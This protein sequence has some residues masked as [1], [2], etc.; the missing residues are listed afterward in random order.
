MTATAPQ[1]SAQEPQAA[2]HIPSSTYR[3][4]LNRDFD[5]AAARKILPYLARLGVSDVYLS[6]IWASTPG[7]PHGYDVT[8]H[9]AVNPELGGMAGLRKFSA[10]ARELGLSVVVDFV[11]NHMGIQGGHNPYWEDVLMHGQ[12][13]RYAHFFDISWQ[14]LKRALEGKV[15]LP[16]LGE[17]YGRVL[18]NGELKLEQSEGRFFLRYW[19]RALP[20]S[21][22]S[23]ALV[24]EAAREHLPRARVSPVPDAVPHLQS[25]AVRAELSSL[26]RSV[27]NLPRS[28]SDA[29]TDEDR[30]D[31]AQE[32]DVMTR[33]LQAL[34]NTSAE[35]RG[36]LEAAL[37]A[38]NADTTRLDAIISEQ[39]YRLAFWKVA[40]EEINYRRFFDINDLAAL[41]M[42]DPRVFSW[43]HATLFELVR[44]GV[45]Q[46]VRL[47]HTDGLYDP[48]G[49]FRALQ[50]GAAEALGVDWNPE[51][52]G[53]LPLYVVAEKILE[54][55]EHLPNAWAVYGTTGYDFLAELN[56]VFVDATHE[57]EISAVYRRFTGDRLSYGEH[58]YRGKQLIQRVSLPGEVNV[59]TESLERLGEADLRSRDFTLSALRNAVREVIATFPVYR[60]YLR[61]DGS[62]EP[63]DNAK[64]AKAVRD[65]KIQNRREGGPLDPS[66]FDYLGSV[67]TMDVAD[68]KTRDAYAN[69]ALSFQQLTGPVTAKGAED[70]A[71]YRYAR[72]L[73]LNEVGGDPAHFGTRLKDFHRAAQERAQRWP[74]AMLS[75]STHD[76]K[77]GE[78]TR[79]RLSVLSE[80]PQVWGAFVRRWAPVILEHSQEQEL[81]LA[82]SPLDAYT[83]LQT[84]LGAYPLDG[85]PDD[86]ADRLSAYMLKASREAKLRTS[87]A[88]PDE[89]Y[90]A[91]LDSF[92]RG[93]LADQGFA[94][95][96]RDLHI[97]ISPYGAQNGLSATLA[98]LTAPGV[99]DTY[100]GSEGWNQSLVDPD[101]RRP[102]D[103][104]ALQRRLTR[105][106][107]GASLPLASKLLADYEDGG[108]KTLV[109]WAALQTRDAHPELF[110]AGSY[111]PLDAGRHLLAFA[112]EH[113]GELAVTVAPRLTL[114]LTRQ[115]VPWALGE[116]WGTRQ[117]TLPGS[118]MFEN[119]LTGERFRVRGGRIPLAKV[120]EEFPL[121]LL[122]KR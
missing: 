59:L 60:T 9:S 78:D 53:P 23:I 65:A 118:G 38:I 17:Q 82:P 62:R 67:L 107:K 89:D 109:T 37:A 42:E 92:V 91:A 120:L 32:L 47:D 106:E 70:T 35:V 98:R 100:Q 13:S 55:G 90:E 43:A 44:G 34:L 97:L 73:S 71:F 116:V 6:P 24:L 102:V 54:P 52:G 22:R 12:A 15:L 61:A 81:G 99:P 103:Y 85:R 30:L 29:L 112:R 45:I 4:Q 79:A 69:F 1:P 33:R 49:Y 121:A 94:A 95:A 111:R 16:V 114:T 101:N 39:N 40:A 48:A 87:W 28:T 119:V 50:A 21:P 20:L 76:T 64:I 56:G 108:I 74:H 8:D 27:D 77:R 19:E 84:A 46:G 36:A 2:P 31:R 57:D 75:G 7:S 93:L 11:P 80:I 51:A 26:A 5:F 104:P 113:G 41:R 117:L 83:Y 110:Q 3:L 96:L 122:V 25:D 66:V 115:V 10:R 63:G 88:A 68:D 105:L 86:L 18:E 72:L 14:P 58:L